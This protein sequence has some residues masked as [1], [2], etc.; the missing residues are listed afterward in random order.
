MQISLTCILERCGYEIYKS[1]VMSLELAC[2]SFGVFDHSQVTSCNSLLS[3]LY[4]FTTTFPGDGKSVEE[5]DTQMGSGLEIEH[6][7]QEGIQDKETKSESM[8]L[9]LYLLQ[10][11]ASVSA[12]IRM[13]YS[14]A[15]VRKSEKV[16]KRKRKKEK[17]G[18]HVIRGSFV[19]L[20]SFKFIVS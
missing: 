5:V 7:V 1:V 15:C 17:R 6:S 19:C 20:Q 11:H 10:L 3:C 12:D 2:I 18:K 4:S 13:N 14:S 16:L 8:L 9:D